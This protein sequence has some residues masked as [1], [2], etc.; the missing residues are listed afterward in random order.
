MASLDPKTEVDTK[1]NRLKERLSREPR[2]TSEE[3]AEC[4]SDSELDRLEFFLPLPP[5]M[6]P[7]RGFGSGMKRAE[8]W[9]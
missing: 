7:M 3:E 4:T 9:R 1:L 2:E 8:T 5:A 6:S